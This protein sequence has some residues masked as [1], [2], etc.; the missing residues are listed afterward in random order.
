MLHV[1]DVGLSELND[2]IWLPTCTPRQATIERGCRG[3]I[4]NIRVNVV[5]AMATSRTQRL[6]QCS[7]SAR[8]P[9]G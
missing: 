7:L 2:S 8:L 9:P 5:I 4:S 6:S 3:R 1:S